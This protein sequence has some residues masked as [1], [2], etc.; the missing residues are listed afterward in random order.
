[1]DDQVLVYVIPKPAAVPASTITAG[2]W[3][4]MGERVDALEVLE[5][6]GLADVDTS[7]I[8][9]GQTLIYNAGTSTYVAGDP[10]GAI[11]RIDDHTSTEVVADANRLTYYLGLTATAAGSG[12]AAV[13]VRFAGS[14]SANMVARSDHSHS[15]EVGDILTGAATGVLSSGTRT[16]SSATTATLASG[17]VYDFSA[18]A[19]VVCRNNV[20][21]GTAQLLFRIGT[22]SG[23]P[24]RS[25]PLLTVGGVPEPS[26]IKFRGVIT[27]TGAGVPISFK[28]Q[29][30][31]GDAVD[32]RDWELEYSFRPRS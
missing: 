18:S 27:G 7:G 28:I 21:S 15:A 13:S 25:R 32:V 9:D 5:L 14:G 10:S 31:T 6:D 2:D 17:T 3:T 30:L 20:N 16:L 8:T 26:D 1:M 24:E 12:W 29:F 11:S 22:E 19:N 23:Y 4:T